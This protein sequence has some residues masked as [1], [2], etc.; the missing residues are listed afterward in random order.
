MKD[1]NKIR[2]IILRIIASSTKEMKLCRRYLFLKSIQR[3]I[4]K[5]FFRAFSL[6]ASRQEM[7]NSWLNVV[8]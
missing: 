8:D 1:N 3:K 2:R 6:E 7:C 4:A 5:L